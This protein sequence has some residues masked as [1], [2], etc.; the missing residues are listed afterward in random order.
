MAGRKRRRGV[1]LGTIFMLGL[2]AL[3]VLLCMLFFAMLGG[4]DLPERTEAFIRSL[5]EQETVSPSPAPQQ[6][7]AAA[8]PAAAEETETAAP[9]G[10]PATPTPAPAPSTIHIAAAGTVYAPKAVRESTQEGSR[11][12]FAPVFEGLFDALSGADLAIATLETTTAGRDKG[13]GNYNTAPEILTALRGCGVDLIALATER[14]LEKGYEGLELTVQELT[15]RGLAYAGVYPDGAQAGA[16]TMMRIGGVQ[17]AVLAYTYGLSD[18]G[19]SRTDG[20]ARGMVALMDTERMA[21]DIR[22]ARVD[23]ANVV[24]V[25]PHWGTKNKSETDDTLRRMAAT[26][27]EAGADIILGTHPNV[28]QGTQRLTVTRSD[29]LEYEAVVCYSLGTLLTDAR[30]EENTAGMIAHISVTYDPAT[31]RATL[32]ETAFTPVYIACQR[33]DGAMAYRVVDAQNGQA[34]GLLTAQEQEA[35]QRAAEIIRAATQ[36][37]QP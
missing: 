27:A 16:A 34:A 26:L 19:R 24:I 8:F 11:Y 31:R 23:G 32:G 21:R 25:L 37:G 20:D 13:F 14:A 29:G 15:A 36:E 33:E 28:A 35:A 4:G 10:A 12:D 5:R 17:V 9:T 2:T 1:S 18:E 7:A 30:T 3:V 6:T 22:Q